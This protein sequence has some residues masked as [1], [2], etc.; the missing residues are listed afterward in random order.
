M[1]TV[2]FAAVSIPSFTG[3]EA[4]SA[5]T[6]RVSSST[7]KCNAGKQCPGHRSWLG[8]KDGGLVFIPQEFSVASGEKIVFKNVGGSPHNVIFDEDEIPS[9]V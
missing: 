2:T 6:S 9:G 8:T 1:A 3:L 7:V 4:A 5:P